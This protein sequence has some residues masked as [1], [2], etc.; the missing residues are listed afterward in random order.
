M[1]ATAIVIFVILVGLIIMQLD[2]LI[3]Q[4]SEIKDILKQEDNNE[5]GK[6]SAE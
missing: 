3:D 6:G 2:M 5:S 4:V 1:I